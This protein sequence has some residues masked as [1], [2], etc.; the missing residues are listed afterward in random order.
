[1]E[2]DLLYGRSVIWTHH[3]P[4]VSRKSDA[5]I[6]QRIAALRTL[7]PG[8]EARCW[9]VSVGQGDRPALV[10]SDC[11]VDTTGEQHTRRIRQCIEYSWSPGEQVQSLIRRLSSGRIVLLTR[12][13]PHRSDGPAGGGV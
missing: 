1:M 8:G 4:A 11:A 5:R 12:D 2:I 7:R 9:M 13:A 10:V 6:L 3:S